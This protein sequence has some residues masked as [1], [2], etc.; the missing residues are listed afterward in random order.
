MMVC[1][2]SIGKNVHVATEVSSKSERCTFYMCGLLLPKTQDR[3]WIILLKKE[4]QK[5]DWMAI[6]IFH[7][8]TL[9]RCLLG[10]PL[11]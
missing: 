7:H 1:L 10:G 2:R 5:S 11:S 4:G 9:W 3:A 8:S 6:S